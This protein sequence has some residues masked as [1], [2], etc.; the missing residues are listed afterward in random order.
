MKQQLITNKY[1]LAKSNIILFIGI[2]IILGTG[3]LGRF[4][5]LNMIPFSPYS[6]NIGGV[7]ALGGL[8][9]HFYCH[10]AHKQSPKRSE[11]IEKI[12]QTGIYQKVRHPMYLGLIFTFFGLAIL[13]GI[14]LAIIPAIVF[15]VLAIIIALKEEEFLLNKFGR[16]YEEY[17]RKVPWRF[18]P[19]IF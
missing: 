12:I 2:L 6:N 1:L 14:V 4:F 15:S 11:Q 13:F 16:E 10:R 9:F 18:I 17:M 3:V 5:Q 19:K 7:I 8:L